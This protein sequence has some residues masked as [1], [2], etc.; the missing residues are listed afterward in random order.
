MAKEQQQPTVLKEIIGDNIRLSQCKVKGNQAGLFIRIPD[1][2]AKAYSLHNNSLMVMYGG[3]R[4]F[5]ILPTQKEQSN[6]TP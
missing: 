4:G 2:L 1:N 5:L 6:H 3:N